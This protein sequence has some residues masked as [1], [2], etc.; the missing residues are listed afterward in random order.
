MLFG[1]FDIFQNIIRPPRLS[2]GLAERVR[3]RVLI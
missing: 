1:S 3:T 2:V